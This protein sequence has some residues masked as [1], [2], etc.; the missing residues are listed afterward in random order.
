MTL[1]EVENVDDGLQRKELLEV[2]TTVFLQRG[3]A[4][5]VGNVE[6]VQHGMYVLCM[7]GGNGRNGKGRRGEQ[8]NNNSTEAFMTGKVI[9]FA[10]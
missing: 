9:R 1:A 5:H 10:W 2:S 8:G 6:D 7:S 4:E 3:H